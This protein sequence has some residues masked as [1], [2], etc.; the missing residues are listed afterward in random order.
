MTNHGSQPVTV[1]PG[2]SGPGLV[3]LNSA[4]DT[5]QPGATA[6]HD[7]A[8]AV[9][10]FSTSRPLPSPQALTPHGP[11]SGA[12]P[13]GAAYAHMARYWNRRLS[14]I[15][16]LS[17]PNVPLPGTNNLADPG[18]AIGNAYKAAFVYTRIVQVAAA[19]F[20]G[21]D[22]YD[23]L[24]NH[25]LP[26]ILA[27]R[28]ALGDF[29]DARNLLLVGRISESPSFSEVGANWYWDGVWRTPL[30]WAE[31]LELTGDTAFVRQYFHDDATGPSPWG[32]SLYTMMH[33]DYLSQLDASTGYLKA[34][35]D[36]DSYGTWLFDDETAL[37]G[38]A[39]YR[40]IA[41]RIGEGAEARW[42]GQAYTKLLDA[43]NAG[44]AANEKANGFSFLPC[45]VSQP[46]TADRC[47]TPDDANWAGSNLWGQN[48]WTIYLE[49]GRLD[50][51]LG[52]PGQTD[53]LYRMGFARLAGSVPFPSFGAYTGYSVALNTAYAAGALY[54]TAY[55]DLPVT[56]YA[57]QIA[58]TTGGP[59]AW[60]EANGSPP[61]PAN[62][63][64][65]SHAAPEFGAIP[66]AWPMAGQTQTLLQSLAAEG[67]TQ[68]AG[69]HGTGYRPVLYIGRGVPDAWIT[70]GQSVTVSNLTSS[71]DVAS[72][73]RGT[74]GV[75]ITTGSRH[76]SRA[77]QV[78][79]TG[80]V[81]S[82]DIQVQLPVFADAGVRSVTG[83]A[84][85]AA[86]H[87]V[88]VTPGRRAVQVLL[89]DAARP[90][91]QVSVT[92][93]AG[94]QHAQPMLTDGQAATAS[95]TITNTG[96]SPLTGVRLTL[97]APGGWTVTAVSPA[98]FAQLGPGQSQTATWQVTPASDADGG[99][100]LVAS[101]AYTAPY[102]TSGS[103]SAEQWVR[104]QPPLPL[105]PGAEDLA[106]SGSPSAS[107]TSPWT[108][109]SAI[110]DGIYPPRSHDTADP[111]WGTWP[112][113]GSQWIEL[114]WAKPVTAD[115]AA[116][117]FWSDGS[118]VLPPASW[119]I[120]YWNGSAFV[121]VTGASGY[122]TKL[123]TFNSVTF[124]P[125]TTTRL[126][127]VFDTGYT[128]TCT[129][130]C[131]RTAVPGRHPRSRGARR[132]SAGQARLTRRGSFGQPASR[133]RGLR[134]RGEGAH[135]RWHQMSPAGVRRCGLPAGSRHGRAPHGET[136]G[137]GVG[138][139]GGMAAQRGQQVPGSY[140]ADI[141]QAHVDAGERR[142][143]TE[144]HRLPVVEARHRD[145]AGH[146]PPEAT[147]RVDDAAGD[148]IAA[149]EDGIGAGRAAE[150][151]IRRLAA[152][153]L[154]PLAVQHVV[155]R[156]LQSRLRHRVEKPLC[157][158]ARRQEPLRAR[159]VPD[160][161]PPRGDQVAGGQL[162]PAVVVGH[163]RRAVPLQR[164]GH[165]VHHRGGAGA[166]SRPRLDPPSRHDQAVNA[167]GEQQLDVPALAR[168]IVAGIAHEHRD[169]PGSQGILRAEHHR[170]AEPAEA[171]G[172][173]QADGEGPASQQGPGVHVGREAELA[174]RRRHTITGLRAHRALAVQRLRGRADRHP[175]QGRDI[176]D[177]RP[178][179]SGSPLR[180][181]LAPSADILPAPRGGN[182]SRAWPA[183]PTIARRT[184]RPAITGRRPRTAFRPSCR[185]HRRRHAGTIIV[186]A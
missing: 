180:Q 59:D 12:L 73:R 86:T 157:A 102:G 67:L 103:V 88:T 1:P 64:A 121:P 171:V 36:N 95:A 166:Q 54:G 147:Q 44:L 93:T 151:D 114:D 156:G 77:V 72:G 144:D 35:F 107:Y 49:G 136:A 19:P 90:A 142:L 167:A 179:G 140:P 183:S 69:G 186:Q 23:W 60:W 40:Y 3:A 63:W 115:A 176:P 170:D 82:D 113:Q 178:S 32:P 124:Q 122:G 85:D 152:P 66:Y 125:V 87:T 43:T 22:N 126:R 127:A 118:G 20:S 159:D 174:R 92:S 182:S 58:T 38:L 18:T 94:G 110:N 81:P 47:G 91:L 138:P 175:R 46:V 141:L 30:A 26:G 161:A 5:V 150:Q 48:A 104:A 57:W 168:R 146:L 120:Q 100:G 83:G 173:D 78:T 101:A 75:R 143:G 39:A 62:P 117:Y 134:P 139:T 123:D 154:A 70:P 111:Y 84:Y 79:L 131:D 42:A 137:H 29:T 53:S 50:G 184:P 106:P 185:G 2:Q 7:F 13:Y 65:G 61:D 99:Y 28:F 68:A 129:G 158:L 9:D 21:A 116:I 37:A 33:T 181:P 45:E 105:Q 8:A 153:A 24:L 148:L 164:L 71:Y 10:T 14:V 119:T 163:D 98:S 165:R 155:R 25:D 51:I 96:H 55:R 16:R 6:R 130:A 145:V 15:P 149:A 11:H 162:P 112:Q 34:S 169:L 74:Y 52:D 80:R 56:S 41:A 132:G 160:L 76:G 128:G 89:G 17:L 135:G 177:R 133:A 31:Y 172:R 109:V 108:T 27:N 97:T 4:P